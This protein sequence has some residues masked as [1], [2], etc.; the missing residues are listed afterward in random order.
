M[1]EVKGNQFSYN[2]SDKFLRF[3]LA[4]GRAMVFLH[5]TNGVVE[6]IHIDMLPFGIGHSGSLDPGHIYMY[7]YVRM[8]NEQSC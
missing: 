7:I 2:T 4:Y 1:P 6:T 8:E 5:A 3:V